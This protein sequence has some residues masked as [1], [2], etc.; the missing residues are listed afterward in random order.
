[1]YKI[2]TDK[3][4]IRFHINEDD[5]DALLDKK[6][7]KWLYVFVGYGRI[8]VGFV[9]KDDNIKFIEFHVIN[10]EY[11]TIVS[12]EEVLLSDF[13][14]FNHHL[15]NAR[16]G[17][18]TKIFYS[19]GFRKNKRLMLKIKERLRYPSQKKIP[20]WQKEDSKEWLNKF[21]GVEK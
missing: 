12:S 16:R 6:T 18:H 20:K 19:K 15:R 14:I 8:T 21:F 7:N 11:S 10:R 5:L 3:T 9:N 4:R 2:L 13:S 17:N 1:M